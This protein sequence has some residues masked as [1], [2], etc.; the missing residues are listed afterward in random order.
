MHGYLSRHL[1]QWVLKLNFKDMFIDYDAE[2]SEHN[3][4]AQ[5][6]CK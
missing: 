5:Y 4:D 1:L 2:N 3:E 6:I